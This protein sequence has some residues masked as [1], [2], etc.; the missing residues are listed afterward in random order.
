MCNAMEHEIMLPRAI[1]CNKI[2]RRRRRRLQC[3][4]VLAMRFSFHFIFWKRENDEKT[5]V[6]LNTLSEFCG[7]RASSFAIPNLS[8]IIV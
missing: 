8:N 4:I 5:N 7:A 3:E 1:S 6:K 2:L